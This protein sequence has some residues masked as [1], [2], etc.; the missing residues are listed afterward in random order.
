MTKKIQNT[1]YTK[2]A[3]KKAIVNNG[4]FKET[5]TPQFV[6]NQSS[7]QQYTLQRLKIVPGEQSYNEATNLRIYNSNTITVFSNAIASS[8]QIQDQTLTIIIKSRSS[9]RRYSVRKGVLRTFAKFTEKHL[10]QGLFFSKVAGFKPATLFKKRL[11]HR[12]FPVNFAKVLRTLSLQ[13]TCKR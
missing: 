7:E 9:H 10:C 2:K 1:S 6:E 11:W 13:N 12:C 3:G 5:R 8:A 4:N